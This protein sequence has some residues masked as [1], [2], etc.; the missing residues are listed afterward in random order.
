MVDDVQAEFIPQPLHLLLQ[1]QLQHNTCG[2][3][4]HHG[5][6]QLH[7]DLADVNWRRRPEEDKDQARG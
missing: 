4:E 7:E 3:G 1:E 2:E 6:A 5:E